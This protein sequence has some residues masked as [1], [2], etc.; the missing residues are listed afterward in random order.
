MNLVV[1]DSSSF[2]FEKVL[3]VGSLL[4]DKMGGYPKTL[5]DITSQWNMLWPCK[6]NRSPLLLGTG[7]KLIG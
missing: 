1:R 5:D 6:A 2:L 4:C 3:F 7:K